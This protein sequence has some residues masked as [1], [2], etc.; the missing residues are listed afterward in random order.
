[1][2][3]PLTKARTYEAGR[4]SQ[5]SPA[6]R[7]GFHLSPRVGWMNDPNGFSW[8][9]GQ[10]HLFYQYN[11]YD[12]VWGP[13]HWGH[14]VSRDLLHWQSLPAALAPDTP[15]DQDG[16]FSGSAAAL[17]DGRHLLLYTGVRRKAG[18]DQFFQTQCL[19]VGDG[20]NYEKYSGNPVLDQTVLPQGACPYDFRDPKLWQE[21]DGTF[22][23]VA[24]ARLDGGSGSI[25]HFRS[26]D[27]FHWEPDGILEE[28]RLG[29]GCMWE[30]PDYFSLD[31]KQ[32]LL[33]SIV[34]AQ[35]VPVDGV[36]LPPGNHVLCLIG[37]EGPDGRFRQESL[38]AV[39]CGLD[40]YAS[41]T[42]LSPDGRRIL[43]GW[44][45]SWSALD[46][47][48]PQPLPW[49]GQITLPRE[50]SLREGRL[51]Q[52]PIRELDALR[53][54]AQIA[55]TLRVEGEQ[56]LEAV[57]GSMLDLTLEAAPGE[58]EP[59]YESLS[60]AFTWGE[61]DC[62]RV[63][64]SPAPSALRLERS[65]SGSH[66]WTHTR[67]CRV[68]DRGGRV[69]LRAILDRYSLELFVNDGQQVLSCV[70]YPPQASQRVRLDVRGSAAVRVESYP[71]LP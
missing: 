14:A 20:I 64:F 21:A 24:G 26:R 12:T 22:R 67:T 11:P 40:F 59:L 68:E 32:V 15:P 34:G 2:S 52:V 58:T 18:T 9:G 10:Y 27:G 66:A 60:L 36:E 56:L 37:H 29:Y 13:M 70:L 51:I 1:M 4:E 33:V 48:S 8:Y 45:Q 53:G 61:T 57:Q 69:K 55:D 6:Q 47:R 39:D 30:C 3:D 17:P 23:C 41:Q 42:L 31:G 25:L 50:L 44:M 7:P 38:Q 5:I 54:P 71:L 46:H 63:T 16:C 19:A 28:N 49:F 65:G 35:D 43:V 62:V